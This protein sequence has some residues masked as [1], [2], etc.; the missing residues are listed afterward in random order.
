MKYLCG[1]NFIQICFKFYCPVTLLTSTRPASHIQ[2]PTITICPDFVPDRY[3]N[4]SSK[5]VLYPFSF[6]LYTKKFRW[7]FVKN[8]L[9]MLQFHC[10]GDYTCEDT[11]IRDFLRSEDSLFP[12]KIPTVKIV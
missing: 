9:N 5:T 6:I 7:G 12:C 11:G 2:F 1:F 10:Q 8:M 3:E 4:Q